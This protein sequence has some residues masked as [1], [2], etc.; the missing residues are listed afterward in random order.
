MFQGAIDI[1]R[2]GVLIVVASDVSDLR[3]F[4]ELSK[5]FSP[6]I[7]EDIDV[8]FLRRVIDISRRKRRRTYHQQGLVI[9]WNENVHVR[10]LINVGGQWGGRPAQWAD[11]L[12]VT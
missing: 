12:N 9:G 3:L 10:P 5:I 2:L 11:G 8:Q 4:A 6:P 7:V 1:P